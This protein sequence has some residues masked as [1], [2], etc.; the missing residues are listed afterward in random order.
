MAMTQQ[1]I[2]AASGS[3]RTDIVLL[4]AGGHFSW[5]IAND[6][7]ERFGPITVV[8]EAPEPRSLF[9]SRRRRMLGMVPVLGQL[10]FDFVQ[11]FVWKLSSQRRNEIIASERLDTRR[12]D[13]CRF[14]EVASVNAPQCRDV[15]RQLQP[16]V[17]LVVGTRI[18]RQET[19]DSTPAPFINYHAGINPKYRGVY[20]GYWALATGDRTNF[21][22]TMH[23]IDRGVDTGG[24]L[25]TAAANPTRRDNVSTYSF[26]LAAAAR[27]WVAAAID[28]ALQGRL[29]I[30]NHDLPSY[31]WFHPTI[32]RY[33]WNGLAHGVW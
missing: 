7:V 14:I 28:D 12:P 18:I 16:K 33:T 1:S 15:L 31:Q 2:P 8:Q 30:R 24:V 4:T 13:K 10:G 20:G 11:R 21:G 3:P 27:P 32:W 17:V 5:I 23:L 29:T 9:L 26:L 19:L 6:I 22:V 25:Y